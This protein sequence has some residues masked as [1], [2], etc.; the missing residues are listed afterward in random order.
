MADAVYNDSRVCFI[1]E[2]TFK[3]NAIGNASTQTFLIGG[4]GT[5]TLENP[6]HGEA[7]PYYDNSSYEAVG[8][9]IGKIEVRETI[10]VNVKHGYPIYLTMGD[11]SVAGTGPYTHT[12]TDDNATSSL[13]S[14]TLHVAVNNGGNDDL[15]REY[16]GVR[17]NT[18]TVN[19]TRNSILTYT[20]GIMGSKI[21]DSEDDSKVILT[22]PPV[23]PVTA[24]ESPYTWNTNGICKWNNVALNEPQS[25][26][27]TMDNK[28]KLIHEHQESN[29]KWPSQ[30]PKI[31]KAYTIELELMYVNMDMYEDH[32]DNTERTFIFKIARS[33]TDYIQCTASN[34]LI[35]D[36]PVPV[37]DI[38][39]NA[40]GKVKISARSL[41]WEVKDQISDYETLSAS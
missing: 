34:C 18:L 17:I 2:S 27:I 29:E 26:S 1:A 22:T 16:T 5:M 30:L 14:I 36:M 40:K 20:M 6:K 21:D 39:H 23:Y 33:S 37:S 13:P 38:N 28:M 10:N 11:Y 41:S 4:Y 35:K 32:K 15:I 3:T 12:I 24:E 19:Y 8:H 25:I 9:E 31:K 7:E